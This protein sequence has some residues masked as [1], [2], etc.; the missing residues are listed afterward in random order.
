MAQTGNLILLRHGQTLW[1]ESGQYT[2]RTDI[3]LTKIGE[4]QAVAAGKRLREQF[5]SSIE[6]ENVIVSPLKRAQRTAQLAG[7][8][9]YCVDKN[10]AEWDYGG[11][12]GRTRAQVAEA[13]GTQTWNIWDRGPSTLP[14]NLQGTRIEKLEGEKTIEVISG[15]GESS[16]MAAKRTRELIS[17]IMPKLEAGEN[18]MC[19]AHAHI[20]RILTTQW[21]GLQPD[22][23]RIF[24]LDTA[25]YC[26][27]TTHH[28]DH[29]I[30]QWNA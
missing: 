15:S 2:G 14:E 24:R 29:V 5:G 6:P 20:L 13:L 22:Q 12:E 18:V 8:E 28:E 9:G 21:L 7:F 25:H 4:N 11:A 3:P 30:A 1:S 27:L 16:V 17:C 10:L 26:V 23:A 19:V